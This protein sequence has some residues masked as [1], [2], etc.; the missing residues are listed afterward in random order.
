MFSMEVPKNI[1]EIEDNTCRDCHSLRNF[2]LA[3]TT[4]VDESAFSKCF[5]LLHI[6]D[7]KEAMLNALRIRFA[8]LAL[9][10]MIYYKSYYPNALEEMRN[11]IN[12]GENGEVNPTGNQQDCLGM[13][14]LHILACS[15]VQCLEMYQLMVEKYPGNLIIEDAWGAV[16]LLYAVWGDAPSDIVQFLSIAINLS[17]RIMN[18]IGV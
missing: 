1:I 4:E 8:R 17:F 14:P 2:A 18:L 15:T 9:H 5:D 10:S 12:M 3:A 6:F 11:I 7:T 16:P 13:T